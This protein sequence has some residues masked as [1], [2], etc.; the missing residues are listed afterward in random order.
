MRFGP[1]S[2]KQP[3]ERRFRFTHQTFRAS[4]GRT[5][6]CELDEQSYAFGAGDTAASNRKVSPAF[7]E[8]EKIKKPKKGV[9]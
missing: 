1:A 7:W 3:Q 6:D 8:A 2:V 4:I 9:I 5:E